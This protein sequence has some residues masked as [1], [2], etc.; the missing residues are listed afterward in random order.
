MTEFLLEFKGVNHE[1]GDTEVYSSSGMKSTFMC[2]SI[3]AKPRTFSIGNNQNSTI[4]IPWSMEIYHVL[5]LLEVAR[6]PF[7]H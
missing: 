6:T 2:C 1:R 4:I 3:K 7:K 5:E